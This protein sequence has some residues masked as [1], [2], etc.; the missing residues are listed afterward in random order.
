M[1]LAHQALS[2]ANTSMTTLDN[3][4]KMY[5]RQLGDSRVRLIFSDGS[6]LVYERGANWRLDRLI[7]CADDSDG[8]GDVR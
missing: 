4:L 6:C 3:A 5:M 1:S 2:L 7:I 8:V